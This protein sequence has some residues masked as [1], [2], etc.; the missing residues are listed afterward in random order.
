METLQEP[1]LV[2]GER[3]STAPAAADGGTVVS[4]GITEGGHAGWMTMCAVAG[5]MLDK[6]TA[7][8]AAVNDVDSSTAGMITDVV[9][10]TQPEV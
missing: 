2:D 7:A 8:V 9:P 6:G 5:G 1:H 3:L 10:A 4:A